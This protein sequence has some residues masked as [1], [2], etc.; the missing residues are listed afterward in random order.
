MRFTQ[1]L[2]SLAVAAALSVGGASSA[3]AD[4]FNIKLASGHPPGFHYVKFFSEYF[5][6]EL[7]RR[8]EARTDHT[9]SVTELYSASAVKVTETLEGVQ[10]GVVDIG[11]GCY[12]FEAA[13]LPLHAFQV[14]V[15][16]GPFSPIK[17]LAV[18]RDVYSTTP[19]LIDVFEEKFNQKLIGLIVLDPYEIASRKPILKLED[20]KG[21]K[22][23]AAGANLA[24]FEGTGA[25]P[26]QTNGA[27]AYT[28]LQSGVFDAIVGFASFFEAAKFYDLAPH[29]IRTG[30]GS[31]TWLFVH[32]NLDTYNKFPPEIQKIVD[33]LGRDFETVIAMDKEEA[34]LPT[35]KKY[36]DA[37]GTIHT[38][39]PEVQKQWAESLKGLPAAK[40][41]EFDAK[42]Y[43]A[44]AV[45]KR[46]LASAEKHGHVWPVKYELGQ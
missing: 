42:G 28:S 38:L 29:Y 36:E 33:E 1:A 15:P 32:I 2:S 30:I 12:C 11:G 19:E 40:A 16:F 39:S 24:W 4:N 3:L 13:K 25:V 20:L 21:Y 31:V 8:V 34:Y 22:V 9:M 7:K 37:G 23:G 41:K 35:L 10:R 46:T 5:A 18:A 44:T 6:P 14:W 17:S 26:V 43:P 27:I 45:I